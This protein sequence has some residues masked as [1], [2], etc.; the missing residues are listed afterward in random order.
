[1]KKTD[2]QSPTAPQQESLVEKVVE[3]IKDEIEQL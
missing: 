3:D 1:M 2:A